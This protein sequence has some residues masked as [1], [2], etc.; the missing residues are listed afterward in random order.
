MRTDKVQ[1]REKSWV[2]ERR[3]S[4]EIA[5]DEENVWSVTMFKFLYPQWQYI[6]ALEGL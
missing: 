6:L 1:G 4:I 3:D 2:M 5:C